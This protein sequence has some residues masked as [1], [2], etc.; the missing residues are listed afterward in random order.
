MNHWNI[1]WVWAQWG[2]SLGHNRCRHIISEHY[3]VVRM[4]CSMT[5]FY[6][7]P[8]GSVDIW[9]IFPSS[10]LQLNTLHLFWAI[11]HR[12]RVFWRNY[13]D[14][15]GSSQYVNDVASPVRDKS[16]SKTTRQMFHRSFQLD[17]PLDKRSSLLNPFVYENSGTSSICSV[18]VANTIASSLSHFGF[19]Y[20]Y[21]DSTS[22]TTN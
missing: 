13:E 15:M 14:C 1:W 11:I 17:W 4:A 20:Y 16:H 19:K 3:L 22:F 8:Q 2:G 7:H 18:R 9:F 5:F 6:P 10:W 21:S 12:Y